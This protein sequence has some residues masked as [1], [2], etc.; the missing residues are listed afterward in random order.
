MRHLHRFLCAAALAGMSSPVGLAQ[1]GTVITTPGGQ[2]TGNLS[3]TG[4]LT[5][6]APGQLGGTGGAGGTGGGQGGLGGSQL[7]GTAL[8]TMQAAPSIAPPTGTAGGSVADP[9]FGAFY[10]NPYYQ[11]LYQNA[12]GGPG[13]FGVPLLNTTGSV[14]TGLGSGIGMRTTSTG[15]RTGTTGLG[16]T[17]ARTG[18]T[19]V[20]G[21]GRTGG[22]GGLG[23]TATQS[24]VIVPLPVQITYPAIARFPTQPVA[25]PQLQADLSGMLARSTAAI[26][27]PAGVQVIPDVRNNV[28][29]RGTVRDADEARLVEGM[30]RLTPGVGFIKNELTFP[31]TSFPRP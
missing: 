6:G 29:L 4:G 15:V 17:T 10:A 22:V 2:S 1:Q 9:I 19:G 27:N 28:L 24:G 18:A 20:G 30:V 5:G 16:G 21:L 7:G 14:G 23:N 26:A 31:T 8:Q 3:G 25:A 13:G 12:T 11:G